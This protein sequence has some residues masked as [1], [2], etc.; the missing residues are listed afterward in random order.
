MNKS[1]KVTVSGEMYDKLAALASTCGF[2]TVPEYVRAV[3][4]DYIGGTPKVPEVPTST[5]GQPS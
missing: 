4:I 5:S 3:L 2:L 1:F